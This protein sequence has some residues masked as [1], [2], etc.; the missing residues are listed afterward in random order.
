MSVA[1]VPAV[2]VAS[3]F[4]LA[5]EEV[6]VATVFLIPVL[7]VAVDEAPMVCWQM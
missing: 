4:K 6:R 2:K 7:G 1:E 5:L 3:P